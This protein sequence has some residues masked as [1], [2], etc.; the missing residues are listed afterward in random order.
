MMSSKRREWNQDEERLLRQYYPSY[1]P[2]TVAR[3]V[4]RT[5]NAVRCKALAMEVGVEPGRQQRW[6]T[7]VAVDAGCSRETAYRTGKRDGVLIWRSTGYTVPDAWARKFVREQRK[8]SD[9]SSLD[10]HWYRVRDVA[11]I[12]GVTRSSINEWL[13]G[14]GE[15]GYAFEEQVEM[16]IGK[17]R[18]RYVNPWDAEDLLKRW[19]RGDAVLTENQAR[20]LTAMLD[21]NRLEFRHQTPTRRHHYVMV[22]DSFEEPIKLA[23]VQRLIEHGLIDREVNG[24]TVYMLSDKG[25]EAAEHLKERASTR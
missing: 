15:L 3:K 22:Y 5:V 21:G 19:K 25:V 23:L 4:G 12:F 13:N 17:A 9:V 2:R 6:I 10:G 7:E 18:R 24:R 16:R 8:R 1:G 11:R 20:V 14:T